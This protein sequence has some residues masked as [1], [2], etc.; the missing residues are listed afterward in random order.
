[1]PVRFF[2]GFSLSSVF[3]S[4]IKGE[5]LFQ[6]S[7]SIQ[8]LIRYYGIVKRNSEREIRIYNHI[9]M[10]SFVA[11]VQLETLVVLSF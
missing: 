9:F 8:T 2:S 1:M 11:R 4:S 10:T 7:A 3:N 6:K 5:F